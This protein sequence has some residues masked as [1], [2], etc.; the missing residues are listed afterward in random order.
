MKRYET[1]STISNNGWN[2]SRPVYLRA[3]RT[4]LAKTL[5]SL[6]RMCAAAAERV[7]P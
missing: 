6:G 4:L 7:A 3:T 2:D 5:V 1:K